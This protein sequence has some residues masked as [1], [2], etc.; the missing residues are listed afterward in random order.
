MPR[1]SIDFAVSIEHLGRITQS[2]EPLVEPRY[3]GV[4]ARRKGD[5]SV[6][7]E[8]P[9]DLVIGATLEGL[10]I[11]G[12]VVGHDECEIVAHKLSFLVVGDGGKPTYGDHKSD[13]Q[14]RH[15]D[16]KDRAYPAPLVEDP[17]LDK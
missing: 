15:E 5:D 16:L 10:R 1:K 7:S 3:Q 4:G 13:K 9:V 2:C 17:V 14:H 11:D 12:E 8:A 6:S